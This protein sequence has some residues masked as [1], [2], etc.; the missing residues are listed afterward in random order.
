MK[1]GSDL[2]ALAQVVNKLSLSGDQQQNAGA[3]QKSKKQKRQELVANVVQHFAINYGED[4]TKVQVWQKLCED[5][6]VEAGVSITQCKKNLKGVYVNILDYVAAQSKSKKQF[7]RFHSYKALR[8]YTTATNKFFP[9]EE[10]KE[11]PILKW[12]L[13]TMF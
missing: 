2:D 13:V 3:K 12:M 7:R 8:E 10:A 11:S 5:M 4:D 9:L 6:H 1:A